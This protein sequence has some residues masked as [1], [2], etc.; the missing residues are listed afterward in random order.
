MEKLYQNLEHFFS[1]IPRGVPLP[2][3]NALQSYVK[4]EK[5][6][7]NNVIFPSGCGARA[8]NLGDKNMKV[9]I[10]TGGTSVRSKNIF[11][12]VSRYPIGK[13][14]ILVNWFSKRYP[15][16]PV[17][18]PQEWGLHK[19]NLLICI[20]SRKDENFFNG[21]VSHVILGKK[22][23]FLK[24]LSKCISHIRQNARLLCI[25]GTNDVAAPRRLTLYLICQLW[26]LAI[27]H[28][29]KI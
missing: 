14:E 8:I 24:K 20:T 22:K 16:S 3:R 12:D 15:V 18:L 4:P 27:Q 5:C 23:T 2:H 21:F 9:G 11:T 29:I 6:K 7:V 19:N 10:F 25:Q 17:T 13:H 28:Q 1:V 26:A